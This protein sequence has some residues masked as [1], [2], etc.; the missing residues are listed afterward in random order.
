MNNQTNNFQKTSPTVLI[1]AGIIILAGMML[2]QSVV[3]PLLLA[4]FISIICAQPIHWLVKRNVPHML[5][6][7]IVMGAFALIM[8]ILGGFVGNSLVQFTGNM[9]TYQAN[10]N[11]IASSA[12]EKLEHFG[13]DLDEDHIVGLIDTG[14]ILSF[15]ATILGEIGSLMSGLFL[16]LLISIFMLTEIS[17]FE[18]KANVLQNTYGR[19]LMFLEDIGNSIRH[20]LALKTVI[21]AFTGAL[22]A[23]WLYVIGVDYPL[24]WGLIAFLLNYIPNIGSIIAAVPTMLLALVQLGPMGML[25]TGL[26]Y[27]LVNLVV[28]NVVEPKILG[29]GLGLSTLVVFLSLI[30]WGFLLGSVGMFLSV[31]IT[32][33]IKIILEKNESTKWIAMLLASDSELESETDK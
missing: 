3:T 21:S 33:A 11:E 23:L 25:W 20:Y 30:I 13:L 31:P 1:A 2:A 7:V 6:I 4:L 19:S 26:G 29:K 24:L 5:A 17:T 8:V 18:M 27:L 32:L 28:G 22:I 15:T 14:K 9:S 10:L 16:I 12:I